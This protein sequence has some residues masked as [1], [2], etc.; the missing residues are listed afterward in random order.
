MDKQHGDL[1][2]GEGTAWSRY[3]L[4]RDLTVL[5]VGFAAVSVFVFQL[6]IP[7]IWPGRVYLV[8]GLTAISYLLFSRAARSSAL[9]L[10]Q[11]VLAIDSASALEPTSAE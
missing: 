8:L 1:R 7:D 9:D 2:K 11:N 6:A 4:F 3:L 5:S 10:C